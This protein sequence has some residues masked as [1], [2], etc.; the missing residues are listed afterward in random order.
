[1]KNFHERASAARISLRKDNHQ[2]SYSHPEI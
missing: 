1:V 2:L